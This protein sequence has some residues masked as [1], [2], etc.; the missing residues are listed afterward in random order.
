MKTKMT[1]PGIGAAL[2]L[3][4]GCA[5]TSFEPAGALPPLNASG[6]YY[7]RETLYSS[8]CPGIAARKERFLVEVEQPPN[9]RTLRIMVS[10]LPYE[11]RMSAEGEFTT[12]ALIVPRGRLTTTTGIG[13]RFTRTGFTSRVSIKTV[14]AI[15]AARPGEPTSRICEYQLRWEAEKQ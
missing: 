1:I 13:G 8:T 10:G 4:L 2:L 15:M 11:A 7:A 6:T 9:A 12:T 5:K 14:E 3:G